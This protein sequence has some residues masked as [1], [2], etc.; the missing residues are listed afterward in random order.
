MA[1]FWPDD[2]Q[3]GFGRFGLPMPPQPI[4]QGPQNPYQNNPAQPQTPPIVAKRR[5]GQIFGMGK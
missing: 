2:Q 3:Q 5:P 4:Q 1:L